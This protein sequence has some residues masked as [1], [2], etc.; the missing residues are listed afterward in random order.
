VVARD[1]DNIIAV[2]IMA[3]RRNGTLYTGVTSDLSRRAYEHREGLLPGFT[4]TYDVKK[5][6]WY[7]PHESITAAIQREKRIKKYPRA[8]KINMIEEHNPHWVD[9]YNL[10]NN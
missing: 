9:L 6:V 3:N 2:Y 8:W 1:P 5:L 7:Q 10:L 4:R